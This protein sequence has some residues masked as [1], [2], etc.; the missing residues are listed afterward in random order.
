MQRFPQAED[1]STNG[2][3]TARAFRA[4]DYINATN[5][6]VPISKSSATN[7]NSVQKTAIPTSNGR[8]RS[9]SGGRN[10]VVSPPSVQTRKGTSAIRHYEIAK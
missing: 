3:S 8:A 10:K 9:C 1:D 7:S 2:L 6:E 5:I 4:T